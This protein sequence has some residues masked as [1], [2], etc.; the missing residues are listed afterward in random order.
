MRSRNTHDTV[1]DSVAP[2]QKF[3]N[4]VKLPANFGPEPCDL[5]AR[6]F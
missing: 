5:T 3:A 1:A 2:D 6:E 4:A